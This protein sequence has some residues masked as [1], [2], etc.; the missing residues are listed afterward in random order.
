[1]NYD[2]IQDLSQDFI[3]SADVIFEIDGKKYPAHSQI[4]RMQS[5]IISNLINSIGND[6]INSNNPFIIS[7]E[8]LSNFTKEDI[9]SFL[10][11][12]YNFS[13]EPIVSEDQAHKLFVIADMFESSKIMKHFKNR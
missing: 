3:E 11:Q 8:M 13:N 7:Q 1:M 10:S 5:K 2:Y 6:V 12:I 9:E 4:L